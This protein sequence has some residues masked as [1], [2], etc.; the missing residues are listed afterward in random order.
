MQPQ[1]EKDNNMPTNPEAIVQP[2]LFF[3]G[4]CEEALEFYKAALGA[5]VEMLMRFKDSPAPH[6]PGTLGPDFENKVMHTSFR[7]GQTVIM[8]SDGDGEKPNFSG[9]SLSLTVPDEAEAKRA[10]A[11]LAGGGQVRMPLAATFFSPCFGMLSDRFG[12]GWI[13]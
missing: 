10:F 11:A 9:F 1:H 7:V 6:P 12:V 8:A 3:G 4:R 13:V 2:Y 5:K